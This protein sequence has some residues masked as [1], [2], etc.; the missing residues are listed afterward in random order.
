MQ[1][2]P[3]GSVPVSGACPGTSRSEGRSPLLNSILMLSG[4]IV[5]K[6]SFLVTMLFL[7][8][9]L[10][11]KSFGLLSF[12][13]AVGMV[14]MFIS[15]MG[16]SITVNRLISLT[17]DGSS[18][19]LPSVASGLRILLS[20]TGLL[21]LAFLNWIFSRSLWEL[22]V[23]IPVALSYSLDGFSEIPF[24]V[25]R[26]SGRAGRESLARSL[27]GLFSIAAVIL[28][29][30][31]DLGLLAAAAVFPLRSAVTMMVAAFLHLDTGFGLFPSFDR[32][33]MLSLF[34]DSLPVGVMGL[35]LA[36]FQRV[37]NLLVR[38]VLGIEAV[39]AWNECVRIIDTMVLLIT[40]TLLPG[41]L[42]PGL[43]RALEQGGEAAKQKMRDTGSFI[44]AIGTA[45]TAFLLASGSGL[46]ALLWGAGYE[47]GLASDAVNRAYEITCA[48]IVPVFWMNFLVAALIAQRRSSTATRAAAASLVVLL[49]LLFLFLNPMGL[50]GAAAAMLAASLVFAVLL[51][52]G[53][54]RN[55]ASG[56]VGSLLP[57]LPGACLAIL[58]AVAMGR[59]GVPW[60][61]KGLISGA[62]SAISWLAID[63]RKVLGRL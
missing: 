4:Q 25:F 3:Q 24:A 51:T 42:F 40:P 60:L 33:A 22:A 28:I 49:A 5:S 6:V 23:L 56:L 18:R 59:L 1:L 54:G 47:R 46:L 17:N 61:V 2:L 9:Y 62:V 14:Y 63:G 57:A 13:V 26:A 32:A 38:G 55:T 10:D 43:C 12:A 19:A 20:T 37:D 16:V 27:G 8:R 39:G 45:V 36:A 34:R 30:K 21:L 53:I 7:A 15:E 58:A 29:I 48:G 50:P 41:A 52:I 31:A 35:S 44:L 11:D